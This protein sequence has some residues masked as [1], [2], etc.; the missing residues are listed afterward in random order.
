MKNTMYGRKDPISII[1]IERLIEKIRNPGNL[2]R[3][4]MRCHA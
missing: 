3:D 1:Y 2:A 4:Y